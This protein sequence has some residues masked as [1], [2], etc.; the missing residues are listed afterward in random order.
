MGATL[1]SKD[2]SAGASAVDADEVGKPRGPKRWWPRRASGVIVIAAA[3]LSQMVVNVPAAQADD[4]NDTSWK[5]P[6]C[7][8]KTPSIPQYHV[9]G[10][11][12]LTPK[13]SPWCQSQY[14]K[15]DS[16]G[17]TY[18]VLTQNTKHVLRF[19]P[20]YY[21]RWYQ[22]MYWDGK[23]WQWLPINSSYPNVII[24]QRVNCDA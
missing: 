18:W 5:W 21:S 13:N 22:A 24:G 4:C 1:A 9:G 19:W 16:S 17:Q 12:D 15:G 23:A 10:R 20:D 8:I 11:P 7:H 2:R 14:I 6:W 3:V